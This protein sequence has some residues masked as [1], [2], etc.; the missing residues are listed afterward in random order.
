MNNKLW[1]IFILVILTNLT[2]FG[3]NYEPLDLAKKI[4]GK[5]SLTNIMEYST[6]EYQGKPNGQD[7]Q[8]NSTLKFVLLGQTEK[9]AFVGM[10]ILDTTGKGIDTYLRFKKDTIWKMYSFRALAMTNMLEQALIELQK[11]TPE[12][13][14][15]MIEKSKTKNGKDEIF[16]SKE[17]YQFYLGNLKLT[18][19]LDENI[20][21]HFLKN[22]VEFE[23]LK[24]IAL[25]ELETKKKKKDKERGLKLVENLVP[26]YSKLFVS[27]ITFGNDEVGENCLVFLIGGI[28]D[29]T[30]GYLY[31]KDKKDLPKMPSGTIIMIKEIGNGWFLYKT[32]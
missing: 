26:D 7:L 9:D 22:Q 23:K 14:D 8:K 30:V 5:D 16:K 21:N 19:D 2:A 24:N 28:L 15:K 3:Q 17:D 10:T 31:I 20:I 25:K 6:G 11:K 18:I 1:K 27:S 32:T 12:Q 4:F 13:I 29:N